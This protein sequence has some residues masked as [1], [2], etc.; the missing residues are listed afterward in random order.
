[1]LE[2]G[3]KIQ[4]SLLRTH[5][6]LYLIPSVLIMA[7]S[8]TLPPSLEFLVAR[9]SDLRKPYFLCF[10][11]SELSKYLFLCQKKTVSVC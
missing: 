8:A 3:E 7:L 5:F 2:S 1:M 6:S 10:S 4:T 11:A 9:D